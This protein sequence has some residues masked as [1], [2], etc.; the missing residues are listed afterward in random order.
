MEND[1]GPSLIPFIVTYVNA[2]LLPWST[3]SHRLHTW[4]ALITLSN[5]R[6]IMCDAD[7][8]MSPWCA[9]NAQA[10]FQADKNRRRPQFTPMFLHFMK[11]I[12]SLLARCVSP[13]RT[14]SSAEL[15]LFLCCWAEQEVLSLVRTLETRLYDV[16]MM[17]M[18]NVFHRL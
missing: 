2:K 14:A 11:T 7:R 15:W 6:V 17:C 18:H 9:F 3:I 5:F 10:G 16:N 13:N 1:W 8:F 12:P 4:T